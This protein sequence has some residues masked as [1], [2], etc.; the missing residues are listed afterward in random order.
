MI[1]EMCL[2]RQVRVSLQALDSSD[3]FLS[4]TVSFQEGETYIFYCGVLKFEG[5]LDSSYHCSSMSELTCIKI[6]VCDFQEMCS[7]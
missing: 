5:I 2:V 6:S 3:I 4:Q 1:K 7:S